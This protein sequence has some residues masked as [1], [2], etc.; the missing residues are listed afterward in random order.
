[1]S[2]FCLFV[3]LEQAFDTIVREVVFGW[4]GDHD[5]NKTS[6]DEKVNHLC[7]IGVAPGVADMITEHVMQ[8]GTVLQRWGV[9]NDAQRA[10]NSLHTSSWFRVGD[11]A[12]AVVT[13]LGGRQGC[14]LGGLIFGAVYE[15]CMQAVR[16]QAGAANLI[17]KVPRASAPFW[18][19]QT[20]CG[21][22]ASRHLLSPT[23]PP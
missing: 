2:A 10:L 9:P 15:D 12:S 8:K 21:A 16:A 20:N 5:L 4:P 22:H 3:D 14:K 23:L 17:A 18:A 1:M 19:Q 13:A 7:A 11:R 6:R